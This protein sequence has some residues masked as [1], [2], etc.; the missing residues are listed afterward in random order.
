MKGGRYEKKNR[1][2]KERELMEGGEK[3]EVEIERRI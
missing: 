2:S 1:K 3:S